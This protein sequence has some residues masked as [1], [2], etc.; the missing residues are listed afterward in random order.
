M[1]RVG[2]LGGGQLA[3]MLCL[4]GVPLGLE[5]RVLDPSQET[6]TAVIA[7]R[8]VGKYDQ[9]LDLEWFVDGL[10]VDEQ[11]VNRLDVVTYEFENVPQSAAVWLAEHVPV[12]PPPIALEKSQDRLVE[13]SLLRELGIATAPFIAVDSREG[14]D[15]AVAELGLP[16]V[17]KTR[18]FGYDGK[19]QFV[20]R[21]L[22]DVESAW[23]TLCRPFDGAPDPSAL[24]PPLILEGFIGFDRELSII[25]VRGRLGE[26]R[27]YPLTEN[28]HR[29]GILRL[30]VAP[31]PHVTSELQQDAERAMERV[32]EALDY[33][34]VLAI[35]FFEHDG[36]LIANE[37]APRVHNS[38]HWTIEGAETSQFENHLRAVV[39]LPL[40]STATRGH[41]AMLNI[42]GELPNTESVLATPNA[43]LHLYGKSPRAG[44]KIGHVTLRTDTEQEC[45]TGIETLRSLGILDTK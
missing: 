35:E 23:A 39:G 34:G 45:T 27:Y 17:L 19:G 40:G 6:G 32:L 37:M 31:A 9:S 14:L 41:S 42:I 16:A 18:R 12:Y 43:H 25:G 11:H 24:V 28:Q 36:A 33:V 20:L 13:K 29:D 5:F 7:K 22:E 8:H 3:R 21:T 2:I 30:S 38:G 44:R 1:T 10:E 26:I 15:S 4:A